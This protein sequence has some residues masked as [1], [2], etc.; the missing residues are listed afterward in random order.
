MVLRIYSKN[1]FK[2][3]V[4]VGTRYVQQGND[5]PLVPTQLSGWVNYTEHIRPVCLPCTQNNGFARYLEQ[6]RLVDGS[7]TAAERC[8]IESK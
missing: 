1:V 8:D 6:R 7:E 4:K 3:Q 2:L 5:G